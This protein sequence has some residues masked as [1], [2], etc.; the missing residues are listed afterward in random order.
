MATLKQ[1]KAVKNIVENRGNISKGMKDAGYTEATAK[2]P[3][4]LTESKGFQEL[5]NEYLM[6]DQEVFAEHKKNIKQDKDR[7]AKN[8]AIDMFYHLKG[9][10]PKDSGEFDAGD[11][12]IKISKN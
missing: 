12:T 7:G 8:K 6:K 1:K 2:N 5:L 11:L 9:T 10:Y 3:K 4:N